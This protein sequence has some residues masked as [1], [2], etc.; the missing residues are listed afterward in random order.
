MTVTTDTAGTTKDQ[1]RAA[2]DTRFLLATDLDGTFLA[3]APE[4]RMR[5]YQLLSRNKD[6]ALV[7]VTGRGL[8]AVLPLLADPTLPQPDYI[9]C[10][11]GAT[12]VYGDSCHP[13]E[14]LQGQIVERWPGD[15]AVL[16]AIGDAD[17][18]LLQDV[19]QERRVSFYCDEEAITP[20][21]EEAVEELGC[22]LLYS[23]NRYLDILPKG[24]NKGS[25]LQALINHLGLPDER[26]LVSG[27]TMNDQS[28][29]GRGYRGVCVGRAEKRLLDHTRDFKDVLHASR[30]GCG[31]ILEALGH[32]N[33]MEEAQ[34]DTSADA[35]ETGK[36]E[37]VMVYHR[38]P[39]EEVVEKGTIKR[40]RPRSPNGIIPTLLSFFADGRKGSWVA[41]SIH[42]PKLGDFETHT[43]VDAEQYP[44]LTAAR[45]ALRKQDV[46]IFYKSFS[47][48][49]FWPLLHTFWERARFREDH[50]QVFCKVNRTFAERAAAEAAE[51][52]TVWI[53]DYNLWMVPAYLRELRPDVRIAFFH[54]THFP[55]ADVFNVVPWRRAIIGSLLQ[56]DY[57]G[58]HIP[59][60]V[61][62]F[63][64]VVRG[65]APVEV[66]ESESCAPRFLSYGCAVGLDQMST[67]IDVGGRR[68]HL[69]AHPVGLDVGR[70]E[71]LVNTDESKRRI[72][73]LRNEL[74]GQKLLLSVERLD[75]TKGTLQKLQAFERLLERSPELHGE[76]T[77]VC[78][79]VPAAK[80]MTI[81]R[82]LQTQIEQVVGRINGRYSR[83]GWTPLQFFF[84]PLPFEELLAYYALTDVMWI[85]PLRDG[86]NLVAKEFVAVQG[87]T[88]GCGVLVLSEFAGAAAEM[89]GAL[90]TNPHDIEDLVE[91][92]LHALSLEKQEACRRLRGLFDIVQHYD[93]A[94]WGQDFLDAVEATEGD[95]S[96]IGETAG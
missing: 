27:D 81:Y 21:L 15:Q 64:D 53:H 49:A 12:V 70:A 50:W 72:E 42:D 35:H 71:R 62:N 37:L 80:E 67:A 19:P 5:L 66:L 74:N 82:Q 28:L 95:S 87:S 54:H 16:Q 34:L 39:Y 9:I 76:I 56:C 61:E 78:I 83:L 68:V 57:V 47:K 48:E 36:A 86:L 25:T 84:R 3:G 60:Q 91:V 94:R 96:A 24:V 11:V 31:G 13:V 40:R 8:E 58:F 26:V 59:R 1:A 44:N 93:V 10:D 89:K 63:V 33:L 20:T 6:I 7:Y 69:G 4:D 90:L 45:V 88:G 23:A 77:L 55:S 65:V 30:H 85:T 2:N 29:Y 92:C 32:F 14:P 22:E 75:Y 41:W 73:R 38:L 79:C 43:V 18:L 51:G 17:G 52:A 46:D